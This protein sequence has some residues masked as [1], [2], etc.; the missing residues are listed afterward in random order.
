MTI[1]IVDQNAIEELASNGF[2]CETALISTSKNDK[3]CSAEYHSI[4]TVL[5]LRQKITDLENKITEYESR[6]KQHCCSCNGYGRVRVPD[7]DC[8]YGYEI[9]SCSAGMKIREQ[10]WDLEEKLRKLKN[11]Y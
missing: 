3:L 1:I 2:E 8:S 4:D 11:G 10:A 6:W 5:E 9:C 7:S